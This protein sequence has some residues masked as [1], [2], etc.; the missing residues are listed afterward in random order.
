MID[1]ALL[2]EAKCYLCLGVSLSEAL[3]MALL[4][5]IAAGG[6]G[7]AAQSPW[8]SDIDGACYN[9]NNVCK[10]NGIGVYRALLTQSGTD[11]P[12]ATVLENTVGAVVF[13]YD[14]SGTYI[15]QNGSFLIGKTFF[16]GIS[17]GTFSAANTIDGSV[18]IFS[19]SDDQLNNSPFEILVYPAT[20][21]CPDCA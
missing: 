5:R 19:G 4:A 18:Y 8:T 12:V 9:L 1:A 13:V 16:G 21:Q 14:D 3:K 2:E 11:V 10:F 6:G 7:G 15:A 20:P 17:S